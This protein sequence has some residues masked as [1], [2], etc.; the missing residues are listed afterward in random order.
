MIDI[1]RAKKVFANYIKNYN[2]EDPKIRIKIKHIQRVAKANKSIAQALGLEQEDILL[3]E[4]IGLLHDIGRFEQVR[5]YHT[6]LDKVS[7]NHAQEG[8]Q[9]LFE[10]GLIRE[11]I[12]D[13][14]Y[15]EIIKKAILNHNRLAIE[16][17]LNQRALLHAKMIRDADKMD[18]FEV[19]T[20]EELKHNVAFPEKPIAEAKISKEV[21]EKFR[22]GIPIRYEDMQSNIDHIIIWITYVYDLNFSVTLEKIRQKEYIRKLICMVDYEDAETKEIMEQV[23]KIVNDYIETKCSK[24][25]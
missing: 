5:I 6:F 21:L 19:I 7:I 8:I 17:G 23:Y 13:T 10:Q 11:F 16:E 24:G 18:I 4:L 12:E 14:Q 22:Q 1:L 20:T 25:C 3:A 9:V 15:D 2:P